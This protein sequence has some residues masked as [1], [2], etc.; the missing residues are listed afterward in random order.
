MNVI[1]LTYSQGTQTTPCSATGSTTTT[2]T[3]SCSGCTITRTTNISTPLVISSGQNVCVTANIL[4]SS[5]ITVQSGGKLS[6]CPGG[7]ISYNVN[8]TYPIVI[9]SGGT[10]EN[11]NR[12]QLDNQNDNSNTMITNA[13]T[14]NNYGE[15][16]IN[17]GQN[18]LALITNTGVLN[19]A[20]SGLIDMDMGNDGHFQNCGILLNSG[21]IT[22]VGG[23]GSA[24]SM[25]NCPT[26]TFMG[27]PGSIL[28]ANGSGGNAGTIDN[29]GFFCNQGFLCNDI[30]IGLSGP[31]VNC[32]S[33]LPTEMINF[34]VKCQENSFTR[35]IT[36][37]TASESHTS[38]FV[39]K[40]TYDFQKWETI[41]TIQGAGSSTE[42]RNYELIDN[43]A[44]ETEVYYQLE[45]FDTDG[46]SKTFELVTSS[47]HRI[48]DVIVF[49][50]PT[51][52]KFRI[53]IN[54]DEEQQAVFSLYDLSGKLVYDQT[55]VLQKNNNIFTIENHQL[56]NGMYYVVVQLEEEQ[57]K[58]IALQIH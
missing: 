17:H 32:V 6:I 38:H 48:E 57:L 56:Q 16:Q 40:R 27:Y 55:Q 9:N 13:G 18:S 14:I 5:T 43:E 51:T 30:S 8:N 1:T 54:S 12:I 10:F 58:P 4:L 24:A 21:E 52:D 42:T 11:Y 29:S 2:A 35:E 26:G 19:N 22:M 25:T 3:G 53:M 41:A 34:A 45:Q 15:I 7:S 39:V 23:N 36:W 46:I 33:A 44:I 50:N 28:I 37:Q 49:P 20:P 31:Q 47:C